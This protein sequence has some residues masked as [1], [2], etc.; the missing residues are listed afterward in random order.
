MRE[1]ERKKVKNCQQERRTD[2]RKGGAGEKGGKKGYKL[3]VK[4]KKKEKEGIREKEEGEKKV[5]NCR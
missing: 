1:K 3:S 5:R 4:K 2:K